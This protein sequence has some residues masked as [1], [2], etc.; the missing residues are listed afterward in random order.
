MKKERK[1]G[2]A[3]LAGFM[4]LMMII[5]LL[6]G[7][8]S[9]VAS[10]EETG[11]APG[12]TVEGNQPENGGEVK[13]KLTINLE[14]VADPSKKPVYNYKIKASTGEEYTL[15]DYYNSTYSQEL[16]VYAS[17][18]DLIEYTV[19]QELE[20]YYSDVTEYLQNN[21]IETSVSSSPDNTGNKTDSITFTFDRVEG[22]VQEKIITFTNTEFSKQSIK[23]RK[24]WE[25]TPATKVKFELFSNSNEDQSQ[26]GEGE[27]FETIELTPS[28]KTPDNTLVWEG[29]FTKRRQNYSGAAPMYARIRRK[30]T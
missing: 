23:V 26:A 8:S 19:K 29:E 22:Q 25:G 4:V 28:D 14:W 18:G 7:F 30:W 9:S 16:T 10:A 27:S 15:G 11:P 3:L 17:N 1:K 12:T 20:Q 24:V 21:E 13:G 2:G 5:N 6:S